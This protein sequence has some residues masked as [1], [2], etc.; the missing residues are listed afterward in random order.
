LEPI[1]YRL[2]IPSAQVKSALMIASLRAEGVVRLGGAVDSRDHTER[3][4][5][6]LELPLRRENSGL[7]LEPVEAVPPFD[8]TVPGDISS[9]AFFIASAL[10]C[11][12]E[13]LVEKCGLNPTRL[14]FIDVLKR[15]GARI[16][17]EETHRSGGEPVGNLRVLPGP[18][19]G[20][21]VAAAE[22]PSCIDEI[23][24]LAGLAAFAEGTTRVRGAEELRHKESDRLAAVSRL[25]TALG[26]GIDL[27]RDGFT[28][29]GPQS[30][31]S[32]RVD[33]G[34]DHRMAMAAASLSPGI[35][36]GVAVQG[37]EAAEVSFP[38]FVGTF[39][40][41]GGEVS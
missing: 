4:F 41:L 38:D 23:P 13:L 1:D 28:V 21:D 7:T 22:I 11:G 37:F 31:K 34:G 33:S 20:V 30:L 40:E 17:T 5:D 32:G 24:L 25:L 9:A 6:Y 39:R 26:G 18:I 2:E 15:M 14:G 29:E 16:E 10:V 3:L 12:R 35:P 27:S 19:H 36:G 8:L